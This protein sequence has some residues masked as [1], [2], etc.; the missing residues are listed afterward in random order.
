MRGSVV[1][2]ELKAKDGRKPKVAYYVVI[3]DGDKRKRH[4]DPDTGSGFTR[5]G[6]RR[7]AP[8]RSVRGGPAP[9][10]TLGNCPL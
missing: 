4:G 7:G 10:V 3:A 5:R 1:K 2:R 6:T 8:A 9:A